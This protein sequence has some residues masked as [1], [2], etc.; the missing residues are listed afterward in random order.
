MVI[1]LFMVILLYEQISLNK[2]F[3]K[4][5][6]LLF[7]EIIYSFIN[8]CYLFTCIHFHVIHLTS[9]NRVLPSRKS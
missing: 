6:Y 1:A 4:N 5:P 2:S 3:R 7:I 9:I 8:Y